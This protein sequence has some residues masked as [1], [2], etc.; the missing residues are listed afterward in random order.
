MNISD[1]YRTYNQIQKNKAASVHYVLNQI[2]EIKIL[3]MILKTYKQ[4]F[5]LDLKIN[6]QM[7]P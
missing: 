1:H 4:Q 2:N 7:T 6:K 3:N 5:M